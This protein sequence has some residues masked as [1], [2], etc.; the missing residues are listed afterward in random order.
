LHPSSS[1][2]HIEQKFGTIT[3]SIILSEDFIVKLT[4]IL[5]TLF[6][7]LAST[8]AVLGQSPDTANGTV[9]AP[10]TYSAGASNP[11][12]SAL[13]KTAKKK[14]EIPLKPFSQLALGGGI[15]LMGVNLQAATNVNR[16]LN[17]RGYGNVFNY[18]VDGIKAN[19]WKID[20][21]INLATA[22]VSLD[23][24]PFPKRGLRLSPGLLFYNQ[25]RVGATIAT[26]GGTGF[27]VK[28]LFTIFIPVL[29]RG[30]R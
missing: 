20:A 25:N 28:S 9:A 16:Y 4:T 13:S 1:L 30:S 26:T 8:T 12:W 14:T 29:L 6:V 19:D 10:S 22:G 24:Y 7:I 23:Y 27:V 17:L 21:N 5:S 3:L 18:S 2:P 15:S 11:E